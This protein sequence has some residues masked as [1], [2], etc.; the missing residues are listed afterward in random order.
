MPRSISHTRIYRAIASTL[1]K[2]PLVRGELIEAVCH[3]VGLTVEELLDRSAG[4]T[5][6]NLRSRIGVTVNQMHSEGLIAIDSN[7]RYYAVTDRPV[8]VRIERCEKEILSILTEKSRTK[9]ELREELKERIGTSKTVNTRDDDILSTYM[10][11]ILKRLIADGVLTL[12]EGIY[13]LSPKV[14]ARAGDVNEILALKSDFLLKLHS[15]GGE[16]FENFF[17]TLMK[18]YYIR[19]GK[20][21]IEAYVAGGSDDGGIDGVI[22]TL[23]KLGFYETIMIQTKNRVDISS[24]TD[25]RGFYGAVCAKKGS[26]GIFATTSD[27]HTS[28]KEFMDGLDDLVGINGDRIFA[29]AIECSHGIKRS[30]DKLE[31]DER[32]FL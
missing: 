9:A 26:R 28:A 16:F 10:G 21:V 2:S 6:T 19:S 30:G 20:K 3:S 23:D 7:G 29:L 13:A 1:E 15:K 27:F 8:V 4:S 5:L 25:V 31:I 22:R 11:Q 32:I 17:V 24:E 12:S 18:K 14:S